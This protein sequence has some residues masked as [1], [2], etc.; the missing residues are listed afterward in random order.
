VARRNCI[1]VIKE[2]KYIYNNN[3][4]TRNNCVT[5]ASVSYVG[6]LTPAWSTIIPVDRAHLESFVPCIA[7][8]TL[9]HAHLFK[10]YGSIDETPAAVHVTIFLAIL[11]WDT[12]FPASC[13]SCVHQPELSRRQRSKHNCPGAHLTWSYG[14]GSRILLLL[15]HCM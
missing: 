5:Y 3:I 4:Y 8:V 1:A 6:T 2:N 11:I 13:G 7:W 14:H 9:S 10:N 12:T 15:Y